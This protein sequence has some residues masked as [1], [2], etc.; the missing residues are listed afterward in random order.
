[1]RFFHLNFLYVQG[2]LTQKIYNV[3]NIFRQF[4]DVKM[5]DPNKQASSVSWLPV[6]PS[7]PELAIIWKANLIFQ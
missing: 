3:H 5:M 6:N 1:M 2:I 4:S 7:A